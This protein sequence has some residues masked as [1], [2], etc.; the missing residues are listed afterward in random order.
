M[1]LALHNTL[2][3]SLLPA[4]TPADFL[5]MRRISRTTPA[6]SL[7]IPTPR[8]LQHQGRGN[9]YCRFVCSF[10]GIFLTAEKL[11]GPFIVSVDRV[12]SAPDEPWRF[13]SGLLLFRRVIL[14]ARRLYI[15][16]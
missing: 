14:L 6:Y 12:L 15:S 10:N 16:P 9:T 13:A 2:P 4:L 1:D 11:K 5:N 3:P 7:A 8:N